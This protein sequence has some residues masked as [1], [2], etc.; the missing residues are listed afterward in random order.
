MKY[1]SFGVLALGFELL[2]FDEI[3][4]YEFSIL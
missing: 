2:E 3:A 4:A 1:I